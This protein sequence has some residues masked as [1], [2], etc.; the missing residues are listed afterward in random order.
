M[1]GLWSEAASSARSASR[2]AGVLRV[3]EDATYG[4]PDAGRLRALRTKVDPEVVV[5]NPGADVVI[6]FGLARR[7]H[8]DAVPSARTLPKPP[9]VTN[10]STC[11]KRWS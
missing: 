5:A 11:G 10:T 6:P 2:F 9:F 3:G 4:G 8:R 7:D 1:W